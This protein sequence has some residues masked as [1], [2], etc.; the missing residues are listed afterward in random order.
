MELLIAT[1]IFS[2]VLVV[3][4]ACVMQFSKQYYKGGISNTT[5]NAAR[6]VMDDVVRSIQFNSGDVVPLYNGFGSLAGYCIGDSKRYSF[7]RGE[8]I[9]GTQ[10]HA[11]VADT[12]T[13][14]GTLT[15]P[16][17]AGFLPSDIS[18]YT[19][20][21]E[22]LSTGMRLSAFRIDQSGDLFTITVKIAYGQDD[23][24][25]NPTQAN[26]ACK[27]NSDL[28]YCAISELKTTVAKRVT[29]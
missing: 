18:G 23:L 21:R 1:L 29:N 5:Q 2:M 11:F 27:Q 12:V 4:T 20:A 19:N 26:A 24:L 3:V 9:E 17:D 7:M 28:K 10:Y 22:L 15:A 8:N 6:T 14:C 16:L 25:T 13:G